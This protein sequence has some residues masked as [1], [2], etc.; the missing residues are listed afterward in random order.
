MLTVA[1]Y[2]LDL[3]RYACARLRLLAP[4]QALGGRVALRWACRSDGADYAIDASALDGADLVVFQRHF[5][6][7]ETWPL[8][9][10]ALSGPAPVLYDLDDNYLDVPPDHPMADRLA[11]VVPYA[12][13]LAARADL[14]TVSC[15]ELARALTRNLSR[16][17]ARACT[18]VAVLPNLL[19]EALW[20]PATP[21]LSPDQAEGPRPLRVVF[22]GTPTHRADLEPL[23]PVL[24]RVARRFG[25]AVEMVFMGC[26]PPPGVPARCAPFLDGYA[27]YARALASLAPDIGLAPLADTPFN[28]CKSAVKWLEYSALGAAGIYQDLPPYADVRH[29]MTGLKASTPEEWED[30][31]IRLLEDHALRRRLGDAARAEVLSRWGLAAGARRYLDCWL[32]AARRGRRPGGRNA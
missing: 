21:D 4:A 28:R 3:P 14:V 29:G 32:D 22:A 10:R 17:Q 2:S 16:D 5:P 24:G 12:R 19:E 26:D 1:A 18:P 13:E 6:M 30:C 31:L 15:P 23:G 27:D 9:E 25:P 8:V 11:P 7:R 20:R